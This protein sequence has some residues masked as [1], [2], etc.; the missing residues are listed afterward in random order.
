MAMSIG[1]V[2]L[3]STIEENGSG[4]RF[5]PPELLHDNGLGEPVIAYY[6]SLKWT[7]SLMTPSDY[8]WITETLLTGLRSKKFASATLYDDNRDSQSYT[9]LTVRRPTHDGISNGWYRNV[10][11]EIE[12]IS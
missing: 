2:S 3:P 11:W 4:Y 6:A 8:D 1:G 12:Y 10:V 9:S 5:S 7:F